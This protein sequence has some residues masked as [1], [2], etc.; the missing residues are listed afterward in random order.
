MGRARVAV[1]L[2]GLL[3]LPR[4]L[5]AADPPELLILPFEISSPERLDYLRESLLDLLASRIGQGAEVRVVAREKVADALRGRPTGALTQAE[6]QALARAVGADY[7]LSGR[8]TKIGEAFSLDAA[9]ADVKGGAPVGRFVAEGEGLSRLIPKVGELA[10]AV[11]KRFAAIAAVPATPPAAA[12]VPPAAVAPVPAAPPGGSPPAAVAPP[13]G[14]ATA[15]A[16]PP[17]AA[18]PA[19][20]AGLPG[21]AVLSRPLPIEI[22]GL[23]VGDVTRAGT[24]Q[25]VV[26]TRREVQLYRWA[27]DDL[28]LLARYSSPRLLEH[29]GVDV[30]D[31]NG[32]GAAEIYV[33]ALGPA[34]S[35]SSFVV[36]WNGSELRP[37]VS[38]LPWYFRVVRLPD[39]PALVGQARGY[40]KVFEGPVRRFAWAGGQLAA[41]DALPLPGHVTVYSFAMADLDGDGRAEVVSLQARSPLILYAADGSALKRGAKYGQ[42]ALYMVEVPSRSDETEEGFHLPGRILA[43][44]LPGSGPVI[45]V[46][47]NHEAYGFFNRAR[48][49]TQGEVVGLRFTQG[50]LDEVWRTEQL[51]YVADFQ[52]A[53]LGPR[54]EPVLVV[55]TV[56]DF[57]G[58]M[59]KPKSWLGLV[60]LGAAAS[61]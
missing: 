53:P 37:L 59:A 49:F 43:T 3:L 28:T 32:N 1:F 57:E 14:P 16:T 44:T 30:A 27:G 13:P 56:T 12:A 54:G 25:I 36:E 45:L 17:P 50:D 33:T 20:P 22:R 5:P 6:M 29:V 11:R 47:R 4:L 38:T 7:V 48:N 31:L 21:K 24:S 26:L 35:V 40:S 19:P 46:G 23:G 52:V 15:R 34:H 58:L 61:R 18:G 2:V 39:G 55:G 60:P 51:A 10:E 41:G 9:V 8:L 42:T